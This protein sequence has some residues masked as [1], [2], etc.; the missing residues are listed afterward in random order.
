M[1]MSTDMFDCGFSTWLAM[2]FMSV[3]GLMVIVMLLLAIAALFRYVAEGPA[4]PRGTP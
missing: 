2:A 3:G 1:P 4:H